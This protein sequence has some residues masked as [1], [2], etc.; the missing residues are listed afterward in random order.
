MATVNFYTP[1][2]QALMGANPKIKRTRGS[3][4]N[5]AA[6]GWGAA[7]NI[8]QDFLDAFEKRRE[9]KDRSDI[10]AALTGSKVPFEFDETK[11]SDVEKFAIDAAQKAQQQIIDRGDAPKYGTTSE[12]VLPIDEMTAALT[13]DMRESNIK[14]QEKAFRENLNTPEAVQA[15]IAALDPRVKSTPLFESLQIS[16]LEREQALADEET[17]RGRAADLLKEERDF[18]TLTAQNLADANNKK[19]KENKTGET[20]GKNPVWGT[21]AEGDDVLGVISDRGNFK[22][23]EVP[24][25]FDPDR[26]ITGDRALDTA[27]VARLTNRVDK[28][29][30]AAQAVPIL[31]RSLELLEGIETGGLASIQ[32]KTRRIFGV[33]GANEAELSYN[34]GKSVLGQLKSTFGAA[35]TAGE[36]KKLENLEAGLGKSTAGN[37]RI[38]KNLL[39]QSEQYYKQG[40]KAA[41]DSDDLSTY[42]S[43]SEAYGLTYGPSGDVD[44]DVDDAKDAT[45]NKIDLTI[46]PKGVG[47]TVWDGMTDEEKRKFYSLAGS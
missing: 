31:K 12:T 23:I 14:A 32:L 2:Q 3:V 8:T 44:G 37:M 25:G 7:A 1:L 18:I 22:Q 45:E 29:V 41:F 30:A 35:F 40:L 26:D 39:R 16:K 28:G 6:G 33:E 20:W 42:E 24:E 38:I 11:K 36:A 19:A 13:A 21:N 15:R 43:M 5:P 47:K 27:R 46:V 17:E 9:R 10:I 4:I 34:L